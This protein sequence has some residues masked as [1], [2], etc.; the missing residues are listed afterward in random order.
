MSWLA[1]T[2]SFRA[3]GWAQRTGIRG[4]TLDL[5]RKVRKALKAEDGP[6]YFA[7][8]EGSFIPPEDLSDGWFA[9]TVVSQSSPKSLI[10]NADN[11]AG[12]ATLIFEHPLK[13]VVTP[14]TLVH[15]RGV[16]A[17]YSPEPYMLELSLDDEDIR[18][19]PDPK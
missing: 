1:V 7:Q 13:A 8:L 14:G 6:G 12:D 2:P 3:A 5:W 16:V 18:G 10:V 9:G 17:A 11:A 15:F 19:L 4:S